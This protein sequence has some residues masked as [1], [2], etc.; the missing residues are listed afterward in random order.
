M[1]DSI[2][3][4]EKV[5][6]GVPFNVLVWAPG[7]DKSLQEK[8][9]QVI[10]ILSISGFSVFT[11]E[12]ISDLIHSSLT[13]PDE[14]LTHLENVDL[15]LVLEGGVATAME[16]SSYAWVPDFCEK[17]II[18]HPKDWDP[19]RATRSYPT[20][21]LSLFP[22]RVIYT[23]DD[24]KQCIVAKEALNRA[25]AKKRARILKSKYGR[26]YLRTSFEP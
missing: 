9:R 23:E 22:N 2:T 13:L 16:I 4:R 11:S 7:D 17:C 3:K 18:F 10:D 25:V 8:K 24:I 21:I 5:W 15:I 20:E 12:G 26:S 14:E 6:Q 1:L 19:A